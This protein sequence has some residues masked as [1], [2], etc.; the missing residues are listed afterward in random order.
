MRR[1]GSAS[2]LSWVE[3]LPRGRDVRLSLLEDFLILGIDAG[4]PGST[5][6][7]LSMILRLG[8]RLERLRSDKLAGTLSIFG[9]GETGPELV[10]SPDLQ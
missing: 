7:P 1:R 10:R 6:C 4:E 9:R 5:L 8:S 3:V 2:V